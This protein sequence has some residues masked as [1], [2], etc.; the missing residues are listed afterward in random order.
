MIGPAD[1]RRLLRLSDQQGSDLRKRGLAT[2]TGGPVKSITATS[3]AF[4][5]VPRIAD[6]GEA[7]V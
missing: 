4:R 7:K 3:I 2:N 6:Y 5:L 1:V